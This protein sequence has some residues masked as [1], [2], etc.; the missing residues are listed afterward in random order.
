MYRCLLY[1]S[2]V[3]SRVNNQRSTGFILRCHCKCTDE[4]SRNGKQNG[5]S[6]NC[7]LY[8]SF[9]LVDSATHCAICCF[10]CSIF[11]LLLSGTKIT[12]FPPPRVYPVSYTHLEFLQ[13]IHNFPQVDLMGHWDTAVT[14]SLI[15]I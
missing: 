9:T 10:T 5:N 7:L 2:L 13:Q 14:L 15:H 4:I 6:K 12:E 1:T 11:N 3:L 8:T